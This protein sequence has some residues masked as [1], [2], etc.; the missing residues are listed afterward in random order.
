MT[1]AMRLAVAARDQVPVSEIAQDFNRMQVAWQ[2]P[3]TP[4]IAQAMD[5][6]VKGVEAN[7]YDV[8]AAQETVGMSPVERA[9]VKARNA[10]AAAQAAT[11]DVRARMDLARELVQR[12]GLSMNAAMAASGLLQAA[13]LNSA[14]PAA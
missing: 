8:E 11:A 5:A 10:E 13:A 9:A 6:A 2:D 14:P 3:A 1:R 7:I 4:A 12:D